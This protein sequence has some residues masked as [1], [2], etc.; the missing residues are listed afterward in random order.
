M[1]KIL[2]A[3]SLTSILLLGACSNDNESNLTQE[4]E[5]APQKDQDYTENPIEFI[6]K[7]D[8]DLLFSTD[9]SVYKLVSVFENEKTNKDGFNTIN[10]DGFEMKLGFALV[11]DQSTDEYMLGYFGENK[12]NTEEIIEFL[13][14]IEFTTDTGE[15]IKPEGGRLVASNKL[16]KEYNPSTKAKGFAV[17]PLDYQDEKPKSINVEIGELSYE[18]LESDWGTAQTIENLKAK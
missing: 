6:K 10:Q 7:S 8:K 18:D 2:L 15:Q 16:I 11:K 13:G 5:N 9:D 17:V 4:S 3:T 12:N 1:R 14:N